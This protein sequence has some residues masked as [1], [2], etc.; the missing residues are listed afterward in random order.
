MP[1]IVSLQV[2]L[3]ADRHYGDSTDGEGKVWRSGIFKSPVKGAV[4]LGKE[5]FVGDAQADLKNHGGPD[6][7]VLLYAESHYAY[8]RR[9]LP[10]ID[11]VY[12]G[13]AKT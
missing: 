7:A 8:W 13:L 1:Q 4:Y 12:G 10:D 11:W 6:K 9:V 3:P 2:G 5:D